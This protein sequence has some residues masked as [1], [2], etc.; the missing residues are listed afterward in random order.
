MDF[1]AFFA[2][3]PV[4]VA[5]HTQTKNKTQQ[6]LEAVHMFRLLRRADVHIERFENFET[7]FSDVP[8]EDDDI[9]LI[10]KLYMASP[11]FSQHPQVFCPAVFLRQLPATGPLA[12]I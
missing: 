8:A 5:G 9:V 12:H 2:S 3:L 11:L 4:K 6:G 10:T 7:T 1:K